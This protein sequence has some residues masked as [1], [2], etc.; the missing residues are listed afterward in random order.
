MV[1]GITAATLDDLDDD[2][3]FSILRH[4]FA[5]RVECICRTGLVSRRMHM[6]SNRLV[7]SD[8][9]QEAFWAFHLA[10]FALREQ[11]MNLL[12][13]PIWCWLFMRVRMRL[14]SSAAGPRSQRCA[15][16]RHAIR[17]C[18]SAADIFID[19][20]P[21]KPDAR[22]GEPD[23]YR[24][25]EGVQASSRHRLPP[26]P[27]SSA[28]ESE[29]ESDNESESESVS[30]MEIDM[31]HSGDCFSDEGE[32]A[33]P[34]DEER[35]VKDEEGE[36]QEGGEQQRQQQ[37]Q[38]QQQQQ[39][40]VFSSHFAVD[41]V[42]TQPHNAEWP[43]LSGGCAAEL[44]EALWRPGAT[45]A[46]Y[47][48]W[49]EAQGRT[50]HRP[51]NP[52]GAAESNWAR[53][54]LSGGGRGSFLSGLHPLDPDVWRGGAVRAFAL[55][56]RGSQVILEQTDGDSLPEN[57]G[58]G[59]MRWP[60]PANVICP[61]DTIMEVH[62][63]DHEEGGERVRERERR[64]CLEQLVSEHRRTMLGCGHARLVAPGQRF[65][66]C[67]AAWR[68]SHFHEGDS[69]DDLEW[70]WVE[71]APGDIEVC[72]LT[73][74]EAHSYLM[75]R[76]DDGIMTAAAAA[77]ASSVS[78]A[79]SVAASAA[80]STPTSACATASAYASASASTSAYAA[81]MSM[82]PASPTLQRGTPGA[83]SAAAALPM[84]PPLGVISDSA[85]VII[86][87]GRFKGFMGRVKGDAVQVDT[88]A[89]S[90][91][92]GGGSGSSAKD[93]GWASVMLPVELVA[94]DE[95]VLVPHEFVKPVALDRPRRFTTSLDD[96]PAG[97]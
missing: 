69:V 33:P 79:S 53:L 35:E 90:A 31:D 48:I 91:T 5:I 86:T 52:S 14:L 47:A 21:F 56:P 81:S 84:R 16:L 20:Q 92:Q 97:S 41:D 39:P 28:S 26:C 8:S 13:T 2:T 17:S 25:F 80:S 64:L 24:R 36:G 11:R 38:L 88:S 46:A 32:D 70:E 65:A 43:A 73:A 15:V 63:Y 40:C 93:E 74:G 89:T 10:R 44:L 77:A 29:S 67:S 4:A 55:D 30:G 9:F 3:L 94:R 71:T 6:L 72:F 66:V 78:A 23:A 95:L 22:V 34:E 75:R 49:V 68:D 83:E 82:H 58:M 42:A 60:G 12:Q 27:A 50:T 59:T 76:H 87:A 18:G 54:S 19:E 51:P 62:E 45:Y 37:L 7:S 1:P 96:E 57:L 85:G 61:V